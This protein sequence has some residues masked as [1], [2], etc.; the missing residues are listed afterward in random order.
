MLK[1]RIIRDKEER[2]YDLDDV[3]YR[4]ENHVMPSFN[5]YIL[6]Y[7]N[8]CDIIINNHS[9]FSAGLDIIKAYITTLL[10]DKI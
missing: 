4:Y 9:D 1:R 6:P 8:K 10:K 7:K 5:T 2:G 3:L